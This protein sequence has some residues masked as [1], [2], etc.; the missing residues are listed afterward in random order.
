MLNNIFLRPIYAM[1]VDPPQR[2]VKRL[3]PGCKV[4]DGGCF[5]ILLNG[6]AYWFHYSVIPSFRYH[7]H[8]CVPCNI[9]TTCV[10]EGS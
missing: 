10:F 7:I 3:P 2:R 5:I 4:P 8:F 9:I 6:K 1:W